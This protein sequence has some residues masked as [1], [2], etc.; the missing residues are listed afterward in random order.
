MT[1]TVRPRRRDRAQEEAWIRAYLERA[2]WGVLAL[3]AGTSAPH[4]NSN[5]FLYR[6]APDRIYVH[7]A[8][9][10]ALP[11]GLEGSDGVPASFT[12]VGMGR[13]LPA[14]TALEFSVEY[15]GVVARGRATTVR[16]GDEAESVLQQLLEKYAPHLAPGRDY[17]RIV[18]EEMKR[19]AVH[20]LDIE[21]WSGKQKAVGEHPGAFPLDPLTV[22]F[23]P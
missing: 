10:G 4:L 14:D 3:A 16:D 5:L 8:R 21:S 23:E 15:H 6:P 9:I 12:A 13:L 7:S 11:D 17:R 20:R 22:P 19:T 18:P 2:P 1:E